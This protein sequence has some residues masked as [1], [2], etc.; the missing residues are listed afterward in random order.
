MALELALQRAPASHWQGAACNYRLLIDLLQACEAALRGAGLQRSGD[1]LQ[2]L[3]VAFLEQQRR[4][5]LL[6]G[7]APL[8]S[9]TQP[10]QQPRRSPR[11]QRRRRVTGAGLLR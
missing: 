8:Q 11:A 1:Q 9:T 5:E 10:Q 6:Q 2:R 4:R 7:D 3:L